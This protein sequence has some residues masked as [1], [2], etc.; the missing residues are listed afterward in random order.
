MRR[1]AS[2]FLVTATL[3]VLAGC[4]GALSGQ[5]GPSIS[6]TE[7]TVVE[8]Q[9][10][11]VFNY[12]VDDYST[13]LLQTPNGQVVTETTLEPNNTVAGFYM[14]EPQPGTYKIVIQQGGETVRQQN[15][16]F[17]GA[18]PEVTGV[19]ADWAKNNLQRVSVTVENNG[20]L[21][22]R[23]SNATVS[24]RGSSISSGPLYQWLGP[25]ESRTIEVKPSFSELEITEPGEVR[26]SVSVQTTAGELSGEFRNSFEAANLSIIRT[27]PSW[28]EGTLKRVYV[29]V[30]NTGD[31]PTEANAKVY[32]NG[33]E[34]GSSTAETV[35]AG[36]TVR[37]EVTDFTNLFQAESGGTFTHEVVVDSPSGFAETT[38]SKE[39]SPASLNVTSVSPQWES[40]TLQDVTFTVENTGDV[41][42]DFS[43]TLNVGGEQI[44][45]YSGSIEAGTTEQMSVSDAY[46][47][48]YTDL[49]TVDS[50]GSVP[51]TVS[52]SYGD[53]TASGST[54]SDFE[55]PQA[56]FTGVETTVYSQYDSDK[57]ELSSV[58]F[59]VQN[60]GSIS[61]NY[62]AVEI[63][64]EGSSRTDS[65][66]AGSLKPGA[67]STE[68]LTFLDEIVL[69]PGQYDLT[70][71]LLDG[72]EVVVEDT[73][74]VTLEG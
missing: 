25:N 48:S 62:D 52:L 64:I 47:T 37:Y 29:T 73:V 60:T 72:G 30:E 31:L 10:A 20:D 71:R 22:L 35:G 45:T 32:Y 5:S 51:V 6:S 63:S 68:Y 26:G 58:S 74:S 16:T 57:V 36:Q 3:I 19:Q 15:V 55:A 4:G 53:K 38:I 21:P 12:S 46:Y 61:I 67:Q 41:A 69:S 42:T 66:F 17:E 49:Y 27:S 28:N 9:P 50:G 54:T 59:A 18:D 1:K 70:I 13:A 2:V 14:A 56:S 34:L 11:I 44:D 7:A 65:V 8:G 23:V 33:E 24:A 43:L 39:L 40:G